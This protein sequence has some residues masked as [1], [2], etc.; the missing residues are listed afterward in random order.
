MKH[1]TLPVALLLATVS[2]TS[3]AQ[4]AADHEAHHPDQKGAPA[5]AQ[6]QSP[7]GQPGMMEQG[8][9]GGR[10]MMGG[11]M[12]MMQMMRMMARMTGMQPGQMGSGQ[13]QPGMMTQG[14][15]R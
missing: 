3:W 6:P 14:Q 7:A 10:G 9:M 4:S 13:M 8:M 11:N 5:A 12:P 1:L 15:G 2:T